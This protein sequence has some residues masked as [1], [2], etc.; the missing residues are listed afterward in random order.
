MSDKFF[1]DLANR[2]D[3]IKHKADSETTPGAK[4]Y[5]SEGATYEV[6]PMD[7]EKIC[8][9]CGVSKR[10]AD[11][12]V[13]KK[14]NKYSPKCLDCTRG[15]WRDTW[16]KNEQ[17]A[18]EAVHKA[19]PLYN[20]NDPSTHQIQCEGHYWEGKPCPW[21]GET[22]SKYMERDH[23]LG[24]GTQERSGPLRSGSNRQ[25]DAMK[26][27][28]KYANLCLKCHRD[29]KI[30]EAEQRR[31]DSSAMKTPPEIGKILD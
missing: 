7:E 31:Q 29:K 23:R 20:E 30:W 2:L 18:F 5:E 3:A 19:S 24:G 4:T 17:K 26:N 21:G 13:N 14:T 16:N 11:F 28:E 15:K 27:P 8:N 25:Q 10:I 22:D 12:G 6:N 9:T 1:K